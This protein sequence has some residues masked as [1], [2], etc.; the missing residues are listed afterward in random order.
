MARIRTLFA[1]TILGGALG[2]VL[3]PGPAGRRWRRLFAARRCRGLAAFG[4]APCTQES[5]ATGDNETV[6]E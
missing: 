3:A 5:G 1:G 4:G 2:V 6:E